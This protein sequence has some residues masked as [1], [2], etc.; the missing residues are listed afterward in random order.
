MNILE[1][2]GE[3]S[4]ERGRDYDHPLTNHLRI[5]ISWSGILGINVSP[6]KVAFCM[7]ATKMDRQKFTPKYDNLVD[8][9]GYTYCIYQMVERYTELLGVSEKF[10]DMTEGK[11]DSYYAILDSFGI[12]AMQ[13]LLKQSENYI[14]KN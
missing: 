5:A 9:I 8:I 3:V 6:I 1:Q 2:A 4:K 12:E 10:E 14:P 11:K 13:K 7:I